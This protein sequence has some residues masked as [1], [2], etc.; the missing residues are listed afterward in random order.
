MTPK[1]ALIVI[2]NHR[3]DGNLEK[4]D[5][6]Y[7]SRFS[8]IRYLMPFYD[9]P[10][11]DVVPVYENS[12]YYQG[13]IAQAAERFQRKEYTHYVFIG[14]DL[15]LNPGLNESNVCGVLGLNENTAFTDDF[16]PLHTAKQW[17]PRKREAL[18]FFINAKGS[19]GV[20][21]LPAK[22]E[23][24][25]RL[26]RYGYE[27]DQRLGHTNA[28]QPPVYSAPGPRAQ[29]RQASEWFGRLK[30][31]TMARFFY[32]VEWLNYRR[33]QWRT[34]PLPF[35]LIGGFSDFFVL[36]AASLRRFTHYC[37]IFASMKLFVELAIPTAL[38]M[39]SEDVRTVSQSAY[40][41][42]Y[43]W[44]QPEVTALEQAHNGSLDHLLSHFPQDIL[45]YHPVKLSRWSQQK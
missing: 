33:K 1:V 40:R 13:Y 38:A 28:W 4:L 44:S 43:L 14:D 39:A 10:R 15:I 22:H 9:G 45:F 41:S 17:W 36:P 6:L 8:S 26:K 5:R 42:G 3:Y 21:Y 34:Y 27:P 20:R 12:H 37:G 18:E 7:G 35:P 2:F 25:L 24:E 23:I 29:S 30:D 32:A 11:A 16:R 31:R 19:E